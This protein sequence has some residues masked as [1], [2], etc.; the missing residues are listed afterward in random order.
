MVEKT[1]KIEKKTVRPSWMKMKKEDL[2]KLVLELSKD[3]KS[4]A[5]IGQIL[6]DEH[7][8]PKSKLLGKK[9]VEILE[10]NNV[11]YRTEKDIVQDKID[12][13]RK[14]FEKNKHDYT[15]SRSLTK[16]LWALK[17]LE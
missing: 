13:L 3:G 5:K 16:S 7:G 9:I 14:H 10:E 17:R 2:V 8:V 12:N 11:K 15:S 4:P 6:R 1:D